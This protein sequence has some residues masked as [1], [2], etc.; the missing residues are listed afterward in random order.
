M[1]DLYSM[2]EKGEINTIF[3]EEY[4]DECK[5]NMEWYCTPKVYCHYVFPGMKTGH[6]DWNWSIYS[7]KNNPI[8]IID[9]NVWN[10][11]TM[12]ALK[13]MSHGDMN[14]L[15]FDTK[16]NKL[17]NWIQ[18]RRHINDKIKGNNE[19]EYLHSHEILFDFIPTSLIRA[20]V[21]PNDM[22]RETKELKSWLKDNDYETVKVI[23]CKIWK[24]HIFNCLG[25]L[26]LKESYY[27]YIRR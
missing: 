1:A 10:V 7:G 6:Y 20:I 12:Y 14:E 23:K 2:L 25:R 18:L 27:P 16:K 13:K 9:P 3:N 17:P 15:M 8:L 4:R 11:T 5:K 19:I 22:A 26:N 24:Q 21:M